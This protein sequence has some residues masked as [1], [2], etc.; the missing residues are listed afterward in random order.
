LLGV[1][2]RVELDAGVGVG[3]T[4]AVER[5]EDV[6][7][8]RFRGAAFGQQPGE[9]LGLAERG[10]GPGFDQS[11]DEQRDPDDADRCVDTVVVVQKIG[12]TF[13]VCLRSRWRRS[14]ICWSL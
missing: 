2:E 10:A 13:S 8:G 12:R 7:A 5:G 1:G 4:V 9:L 3:E 6:A 11:K 14:T